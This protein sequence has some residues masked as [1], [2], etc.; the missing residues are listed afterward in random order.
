M[1]IPNVDWHFSPW[2]EAAFKFSQTFVFSKKT[3][4]ESLSW[5]ILAPPFRLIPRHKKVV[6]KS[7]RFLALPT[8]SLFSSA[9][10]AAAVSAKR[11]GK[12]AFRRRRRRLID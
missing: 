9:V 10:V 12:W 8:I 3:M 1:E 11:L 5:R 6:E 7:W 4:G 2:H